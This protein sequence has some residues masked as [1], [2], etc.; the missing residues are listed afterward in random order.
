MTTSSPT[1]TTTRTTRTATAADVP[2]IAALMRTSVRQIFPQYYDARQTAS[3]TVHIAYV[4]PLLIA[5]GTYFVHEIDGDIVACG[6]WSRRAKLYAGAGDAADDARL[7]DPA[8]E[9]AR[10]RAM[11]VH[12]DQTR[13]GL[14]RAILDLARRAAAAEGFG[15][16]VLLA[17]LPGVPLYTSFGFTPVRTMP[18]TLEDGVV[19]D[20][21]I[22]KCPIRC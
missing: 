7:L 21:V 2:R 17:T 11:F 10:I 6:G 4:D 8:T 22:M 20:C 1:R 18:L 13:R 19:L 3:A 14:G 9:P 12:H 16:L 5:D 15:S